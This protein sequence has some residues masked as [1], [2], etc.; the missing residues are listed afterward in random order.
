MK[1]LNGTEASLLDD[2]DIV[3][4]VLPAVRNDYKA[5]ETYRY[6]P[7]PD[8]S[9]PVVALIGDDD[10]KV[11]PAEAERWR[12]HTSGTFELKTFRGGHFY[13]NVHHAEVNRLLAESLAKIAA[14]G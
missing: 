9:C 13:L 3:R 4:M 11:T 5:A 6:V 7:G 10:P 12:E 8:V 2:E 1:S 14:G